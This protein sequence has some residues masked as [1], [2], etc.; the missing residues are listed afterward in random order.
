MWGVAGSV[1]DILLEAALL[2]HG[3]GSFAKSRRNVGEGAP[4]V[5]SVGLECFDPLE[6]VYGDSKRVCGMD[7]F[8]YHL[9]G[10][11]EYVKRVS[12]LNPLLVA[13]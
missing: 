12:A 1:S 4:S 9:K 11:E 7:T 3:W 10:E 8:Q 2:L 13:S 5:R 6:V